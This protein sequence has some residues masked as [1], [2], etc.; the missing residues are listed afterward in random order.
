MVKT[1]RGRSF[2]S[3]FR[4]SLNSRPR[5]AV[6]FE[7]LEIWRGLTLADRHQEAVGA[8]PVILVADHD[9][10]CIAAADELR[11]YRLG[12][13]RIAAVGAGHRPRLFQRM[14]DGSDLVVQDIRVGL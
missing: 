11:P 3:D 2:V 14:V 6:L 13:L 9:V 10:S 4:L 12:V 1:K 8:D 5:A 7:V